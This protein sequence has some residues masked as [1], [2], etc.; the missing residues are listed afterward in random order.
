MANAIL[1][2][3]QD[4]TRQ[5]ARLVTPYL[6]G[7]I[8]GA[9]GLSLVA[10]VLGT[11]LS[12]AYEKLPVALTIGIAMTAALS[13]SSS[14]WPQRRRQVPRWWTEAFGPP[15][16]FLAGTALGV[17]TVT[18]VSSTLFY[19]YVGLL[20]IAGGGSPLLAVLMGILYGFTNG[21]LPI[22][23]S[24][25]PA[26][27][28]WVDRFAESMKGKPSQFLATAVVASLILVLFST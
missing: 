28:S 27:A 18:Y 3:V 1:V 21:I 6:I 10:V 17:G 4:H 5:A 16:L 25:E 13:T 14:V 12:Q 11:F 19:V 24:G 2:L 20:L 9:V 26:T 22:F 23:V 15:G 8:S 7:S